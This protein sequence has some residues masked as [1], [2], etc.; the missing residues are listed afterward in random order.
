MSV[1][2]ILLGA[3]VMTQVERL[4]GKL[5]H[6]CK[7]FWHKCPPLGQDFSALFLRNKEKELKQVFEEWGAC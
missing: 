4:Y 5:L 1:P 7:L 2:G 6:H 3:Q